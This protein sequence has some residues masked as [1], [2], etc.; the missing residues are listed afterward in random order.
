MRRGQL[1]SLNLVCCSSADLLDNRCHVAQHVF[2]A[3]A[4]NGETQGFEKRLTLPV[5]VLLVCVNRTV[6]L[7]NRAGA[8]AIEID[9]EVAE[10]MLTPELESVELAVAEML[11]R[12]RSAGVGRARI[13][14]D[15]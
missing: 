6:D 15:C 9:D 4:K 11:P 8:N 10:R 12:W 7:D 3:E 13:I 2:V 1:V 5:R 14:S